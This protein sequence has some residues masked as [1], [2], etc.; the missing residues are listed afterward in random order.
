[1]LDY[2][3]NASKCSLEFSEHP[4]VP[5]KSVLE[6]CPLSTSK[7]L[8][9]TITIYD[10]IMQNLSLNVLR[11]LCEDRALDAVVFRGVYGCVKL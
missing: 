11:K 3:Y 2:C 7:R 1:M 10:P 8:T 9:L 5:S 6:R 4:S